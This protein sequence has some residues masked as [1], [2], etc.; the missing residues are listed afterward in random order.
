MLIVGLD[1][2][3]VHPFHERDVDMIPNSMDLTDVLAGDT[4]FTDWLLCKGMP[5]TYS[6]L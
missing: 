5:P 2:F 4:P 1:Y 3:L 6:Q